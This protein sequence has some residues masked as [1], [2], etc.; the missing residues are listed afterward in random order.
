MSSDSAIESAAK[1]A[2]KGALEWTSGKIKELAKRFLQKG[3]AFIEDQETI[4]IAKEQRKTGNGIFSSFTLR[5]V[6]YVFFFRWVLLLD[7]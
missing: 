4:D 5:T 3:L 2:T 1:G 7:A 6:T